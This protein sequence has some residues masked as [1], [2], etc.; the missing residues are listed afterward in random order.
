MP[1]YEY[2]FF[3]PVANA[4][5]QFTSLRV[6]A[7]FRIERWK[8]AK[9]VSL[10]QRIERLPKWEIQW[11]VHRNHVV[12]ERA[13]TGY[14]ITGSVLAQDEIS[15]HL[16][17]KHLEPVARP[18]EHWIRCVRLITGGHIEFACI[19]WYLEREKHL[20]MVSAESPEIPTKNK[21]GKVNPSSIGQ[22]NEM[23]DLLSRPLKHEY[24]KLAWDHWDESFTAH[25]AH[26]EFLQIMMALE[27]LFNV[28]QHD[29]RYRIARS[30]AVLLGEN[31][32]HAEF[33]YDTIREAY[34]LRSQLVHAGKAKDLNTIN[35]WLLRELVR[36]AITDLIHL[37][38]SKDQISLDLTKLGF[39]EKRKLTRRPRATRAKPRRKRNITPG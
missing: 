33:V 26:I 10:W 4:G 14:V 23:L 5:G 19:Y 30:A 12:P 36:R 21:Q 28:G 15:I 39:G 7:P 20:D 17:Q 9:I 2:K 35:I 22:C 25:Q 6:P 8:A 31:R 32:E 27:V 29:I 34:N 13:T 11:R 18:L 16:H 1:E 38:T 3:A 24:I 37:D